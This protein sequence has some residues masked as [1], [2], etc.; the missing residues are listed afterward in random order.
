MQIDEFLSSVRS[1]IECQCV[2]S[3]KESRRLS[4]GRF[5]ISPLQASQ[6]NTLGVSLRRILLA[7]IEAIRI[8]SVYLP[9]VNHEYTTLS[10][11]KESVKEILLNLREI[12]FTGTLSQSLKVILQVQGPKYVTAKDI[13]LLDSSIELVD[14]DQPIVQITQPVDL[15]MELI[16]EKGTGYRNQDPEYLK[17]SIFPIDYVFT[18]I[19]SVNYLVNTFEEQGEKKEL[20]ILEVWTNGSITPRDALNKAAKILIQLFL[21]LLI[22]PSFTSSQNGKVAFQTHRNP[23]LLNETGITTENHMVSVPISNHRNSNENLHY[24]SIPIEE[25]G[26]SVRAHNCLKKAGIQTVYD[27]MQY[28]PEGLLKIKSFG[29]RSAQQ[30]IQ[31]LQQRFN[32]LLSS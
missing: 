24:K 20:L 31:A 5:L 17:P 11:F 4:Y 6:A 27:L 28:S 7:D 8:T 15:Y 29:K 18:P 14:P 2:E 23:D 10:G 26:L 25:L 1:N 21:P 13:C 19:R 12:V 3:K 30:V 32:I 9:G 16:I 22:E